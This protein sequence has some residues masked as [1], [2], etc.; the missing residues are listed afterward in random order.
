MSS[1]TTLT[2]HPLKASTTGAISDLPSRDIQDLGDQLEVFQGLQIPSIVGR[3]G[4]CGPPLFGRRTWLWAGMIF[5]GGPYK[6]QILLEFWSTTP[7]RVGLAGCAAAMPWAGSARRERRWWSRP[8]S[9]A[10]SRPGARREVGG[11]ALSKGGGYM[12]QR[13]TPHWTLW[14][15]M[16]NGIDFSTAQAKARATYR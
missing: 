9:F 6:E 3:Q 7:R 10:P 4:Y 14:S 2:P 5:H 15:P 11:D 1:S 8:S 13:I 12:A 16:I